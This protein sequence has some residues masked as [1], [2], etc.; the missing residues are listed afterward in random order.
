MT[1]YAAKQA[2]HAYAEEVARAAA[3]YMSVAQMARAGAAGGGR[4]QSSCAGIYGA[5]ERVSYTAD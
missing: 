3:S 4:L 1:D 5:C 2:R